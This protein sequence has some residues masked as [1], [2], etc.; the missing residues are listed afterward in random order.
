MDKINKNMTIASILEDFPNAWPILAE[1]LGFNCETSDS[2]KF[3]TLETGLRNNGM[4]ETQIDDILSEINNSGS[5]ISLTS[6]AAKKFK[7][8]LIEEKKE[9]WALRVSEKAGGCGGLR[10]MLNFSEKAEENDAVFNSKGVEIHI[11]NG[12]DRLFNIMIDYVEGLNGSGFKI[13]NPNSKISCK[14]GNS[15]NY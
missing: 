2:A 5:D 7:E 1:R 10:Y 8:F 12:S 15:H 4:D 6:R 11:N 13:G 14:C 3:E 9:G